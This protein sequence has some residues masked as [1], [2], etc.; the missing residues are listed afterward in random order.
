MLIKDD[1]KPLCHSELLLVAP[2][3]SVIDTVCAMHQ[4]QISAA[5]VQG[6]SVLGIFTER[7]LIMALS[8]GIEITAEHKIQNFMSSPVISL[9]LHSS[10]QTAYEAFIEHD[11]RHLLLIG[12]EQQAVG[13]ITE[14][15]LLQNLG[16]EHF[17]E[18]KH[19][20]QFMRPEPTVL[21]AQQTLSFAMQTMRQQNTSSL[22]IAKDE[23]LYSIL[24]ER[25][26]VRL[27]STHAEPNQLFQQK[28]SDCMK[29]STL[30][31]VHPET[32]LHEA[33]QQMRQRQ[34]RRLVVLDDAQQL[35]GLL[36][37]HDLVHQLQNHYVQFLQK[38]LR[39]QQQRLQR[40]KQQ[41]N[42]RHIL[43]QVLESS[44]EIGIVVVS[45]DYQLIYLN[46]KAKEFFAY[47]E[48]ALSGKTLSQLA[49][50]Y[51]GLEYLQHIPEYQS[52]QHK[53][54]SSKNRVD[55][56]LHS[57]AAPIKDSTG[58]KIGILY[59]TRDITQEYQTEQRLRL[60]EQY[61][62]NLSRITRLLSQP[63]DMQQTLKSVLWEVMCIFQA[64][65]AW[66][67]YPC[68]STA[69]ILSIPLEVT[70]PDYPGLETPNKSIKI[71][72]EMRQSIQ[73]MC[74]EQKPIQ[75]N[76]NHG[77]FFYEHFHVRSLI[78]IALY[79]KA[80]QPW[81]LGLHQCRY[82]K[83]WSEEE[84]QLFQDIADRISSSLTS[85]LLLERQ[86]TE[87]RQR[88]R[89]E[90]ELATERSKLARRVEERTADLR[91]LNIKLAHALKTKDEFLASMSHELRTPLTGI[92]GIAE[93]LEEEVYGPLTPQQQRALNTLHDSGQHLLSLINDILDLAKLEAGK[94]EL[95][96]SFIDVERLCSNSLKFIIQQARKKHLQTVF[97]L[98]SR[99]EY[100]YGDERRLKQILVNLL[101]NAVKFTPEGGRIGLEVTLDQAQSHIHFAVW[102]T[103]IGIPTGEQHKL[104]KPFTQLDSRLAREYSGTGLGLAIVKQMTELHSGEI[105]LHSEENQG[106]RFTLIFP[107]DETK[108]RIQ[109]PNPDTQESQEKTECDS[110]TGFCILLTE[111][112]E[113]N[114]DTLSTYLEAKGYQVE[115]ASNGQE[116][117]QK[118][119]KVQPD[120]IL[121]DIQM[122]GMDGISAIRHIRSDPSWNETP[123]IA[124]TALAMPGDKERCLE[125][126]ANLYV[127]KP[128]SLRE[129]S[130]QIAQEL[131]VI[132]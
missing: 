108:Q 17:V 55:R 22:L 64:D 117:L 116:A 78:S 107:W 84:S 69:E 71:T 115:Q 66:L 121:M 45:L 91:Q 3:T 98:D 109:Q 29:Q 2:D 27:L 88:Q 90:K 104:F 35:K 37:E 123:I 81:V 68:N 10:P 99:I 101:S 85:M 75:K 94:T 28:L 67:A 110:H 1:L 73:S 11:I 82:A 83:S 25:D 12:E 21:D 77:D 36:T 103:G 62:H 42:E 49:R 57:S 70:H 43:S 34:V 111:D 46:P 40:S 119:P 79:P 50:I 14:T 128:F 4:Q 60:R 93:I 129:L 33:C 6:D 95:S 130:E 65:R 30:Y 53:L 59:T 38:I 76:F 52:C 105:S 18:H 58:E 41:L 96:Y 63:E 87:L 118:L 48:P 16:S 102:D 39:D 97:N 74:A 113:A 125:A 15:D 9:P 122:P 47:K 61:F 26:I 100:F 51:P 72:P 20:A 106:S 44:N 23:Q 8:S 127:A 19:V 32:S 24:T 5:I 92:L 86:R 13:I 120:L 126:G 124:L 54:Q 132:K 112:N 114:R 80:E 31:S 7:D 131:Q 89:I 56:H